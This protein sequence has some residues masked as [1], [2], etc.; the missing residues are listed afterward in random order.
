[1]NMNITIKDGW[2]IIHNTDS[3]QVAIA[4][5]VIE[6]S[7]MTFTVMGWSDDVYGTESLVTAFMESGISIDEAFSPENQRRMMDAAADSEQ[8][9]RDAEA[10]ERAIEARQ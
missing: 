8:D 9:E 3:K 6:G 4:K 7:T 1:M 5:P 10:A 2:A